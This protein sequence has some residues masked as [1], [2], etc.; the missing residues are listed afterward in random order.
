MDPEPVDLDGPT[1]DMGWQPDVLGPGF[2]QRTLPLLD[3]DE[4]PVLA[5]LVRHVPAHDPDAFPDT[6]ST[7]RFVALWL[8]GWNDY[9]HQRELARAVARLG[10]AFHGL[11]LRKYGRSLREWQMHGYIT[12]LSN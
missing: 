9:F 12:S 1:T 11:D 8:H 6:P 3:D 7:P 2:Q 4:G 5:T 10:G